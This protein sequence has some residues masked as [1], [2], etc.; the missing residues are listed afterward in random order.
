VHDGVHH[1]VEAGRGECQHLWK[2]S[3]YTYVYI[4]RYL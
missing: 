3:N 4:H 1:G 2:V